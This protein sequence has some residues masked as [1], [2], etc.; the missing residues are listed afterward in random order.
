MIRILLSVFILAC[1]YSNVSAYEKGDIIVRVGI[2]SVKPDESSTNVTLGGG[3]LGFG[4]NAG[5]DTQLG[6]NVAYFIT[7]N[8]NIE[9]LAATPFEHD[10]NAN[11]N[12]L[13]LGNLGSIKHLPPTVTANYFFAD[14]DAAFQP[15]VGIGL[16]YTTFFD[17]EFTDDNEALGFSDLELDDSFGLS[18]QLG[19]DYKFSE[20]IVFNASIRYIDIST[21]ASFTLNNAALG[22]NNAPGAVTVD[23]D[24]WVTTAALAFMF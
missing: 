23:I 8:W 20:K 12:P 9:L 14:G 2:T 15:Y 22:A 24:P 16:N 21:D 6:L 3:D 18:A 17:E 1:T 11:A 5:N 19:F 13:G 10:V 7:D 4:L